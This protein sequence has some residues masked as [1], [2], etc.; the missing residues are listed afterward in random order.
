MTGNG[1]NGIHCIESSPSITNCIIT[2]DTESGVYASQSAVQVVNCSITA[3]ALYGLQ[4]VSNSTPTVKNTILWSNAQNEIALDSSSFAAVSYSCVTGG[5]P[6]ENN[7]A[8]DPLFLN[9]SAGDL[10]LT[11]ASP[12]IDA[13]TSQD[14]PDIDFIGT[15]RPQGAG[16]DMGAYE[17]TQSGM[18]LKRPTIT[19]FVMGTQ[20]MLS[21]SRIEGATGYTLFYAPYPNAGEI[22]SADMGT[23]VG[24]GPFDGAGLAYYAAVKAYD[25]TGSTEFSNITYFDLR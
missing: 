15:P 24:L 14:V 5:Y 7:I 3:N 8:G 2:G 18:A 12:C 19:T 25:S 6:G 1:N 23:A 11:A 9:P 22:F 16:F 21:W 13:G 4:A 10:R 17:Y 20:V